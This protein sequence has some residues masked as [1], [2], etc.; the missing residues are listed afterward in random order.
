MRP[1]ALAMLA[2]G[3]GSLVACSRVPPS[4]VEASARHV[5]W[6]SAEA[7]ALRDAGR[8]DPAMARL[9]EALALAERLY[10]ADAPE[11]A[12]VLDELGVAG[13]YAGRFDESD[14]AYRRALHIL[15]THGIDDDR[16]ATLY[17]NIGGLAHARRHFAEAEGPARRAVDIRIRLN[18]PEDRNVAADEGALAS[19]L[20]AEGK[21]DEAERLFT[22]ALAV[23]ERT[24]G[25]GSYD[26]AMTLANLAALCQSEGRL[27]EARAYYRRALAIQEQLLGPDHPDL[28]PTLNNLALLS[29]QQGRRDDARELYRRALRILEAA[30]GPDHPSVAICRANLAKLD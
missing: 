28:A 19:I 12:A 20:D 27:D 2:V 18:G 1:A 30:I 5:R 15:Q 9:R 22:H 3:L 16:S 25:S 21:R 4:D 17:H 14:A 13:K 6:L 24:D 11:V 26:V 8:Y 10:G 7:S 23:F 29:K